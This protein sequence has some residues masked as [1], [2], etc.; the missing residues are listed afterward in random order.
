ML[1]KQGIKTLAADFSGKIE[2]LGKTYRLNVEYFQA[3]VLLVMFAGFGIIG[4]VAYSLKHRI[5]ASFKIKVKNK[6]KK[7]DKFATEHMAFGG[8]EDEGDEPEGSVF[9]GFLTFSAIAVAVII[10]GLYVYT[11]FYFNVAVFHSFSPSEQSFYGA[12]GLELG[13][14]LR[15]HGYSGCVGGALLPGG[16]P[17]VEVA[18]LSGDAGYGCEEGAL[19]VNF[20][21]SHAQ[22]LTQGPT[23]TISLHPDCPS[24]VENTTTGTK[25][26]EDCLVASVSYIEWDIS[27]PSI[28][29]G[30]DN[31]V[32]GRTVPNDPGEV[33]RGSDITEVE[34]T[35]IPTSYEN[36][37]QSI[38]NSGFRLQFS[39]TQYGESKSFLLNT[40][41]TPGKNESLLDGYILDSD[42]IDADVDNQVEFKLT[43]PIFGLR[44]NIWVTN[45]VS[46]LDNYGIIGGLIALIF[47]LALSVM[48][49]FEALWYNPEHP[50]RKALRRAQSAVGSTKFASFR[51]KASGALQPHNTQNEEAGSLKPGVVEEDRNDSTSLDS[52]APA[53]DVGLQN[54]V[55]AA[56]GQNT[57]DQK[58]DVSRQKL[59]ARKLEVARETPGEADSVPAVDEGLIDWL[60]EPENDN[61][62]GD[63]PEEEKLDQINQK[64]SIRSIKRENSAALI[65]WLGQTQEKS[66][67]KLKREDIEEPINQKSGVR[68]L[69]RENSAALISW[70]DQGQVGAHGT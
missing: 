47:A 44:L 59:E 45:K 65:S 4:V 13:V 51:F 16:A 61:H 68:S 20:N 37:I 30:D 6:L 43:M 48:H 25:S 62:G 36:D 21:T 42:F 7:L 38:E 8:D 15:F 64:T 67:G 19:E 12:V 55:A 14:K 27:A 53:V 10:C 58:L 69:K 1:M 24:C 63:E 57:L 31:S 2:V 50:T 3:T 35:L 5:P 17:A 66:A 34:V 26:C 11:Y 70:L 46:W 18:G 22:T 41:Y 32:N 60:D 56:P 29:D 39:D 49:K 54:A 40:S 52:V 23:F 28:Y 9:G 33:F